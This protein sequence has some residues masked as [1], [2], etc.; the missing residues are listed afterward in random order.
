MTLISTASRWIVAIS[1]FLSAVVVGV[2]PGQAQSAGGAGGSSGGSP[3]SSQGAPGGSRESS[4]PS[5]SRSANPTDAMRHA[6]PPG[7]TL[8]P[9]EQ[10]APLLEERLQS[11]QMEKPVAQGQISDRLEQ[12]HKGSAETP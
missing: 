4:R 2:S 1:L 3:S 6:R 12:F 11:G 9:Q 7:L 10:Q 8:K 5:K